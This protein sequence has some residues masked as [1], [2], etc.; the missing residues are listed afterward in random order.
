MSWC[1]GLCAELA[2]RPGKGRET[3]S[4]LIWTA[5]SS[6]LKTLNIC[7]FSNEPEFGSSTNSQRQIDKFLVALLIAHSSGHVS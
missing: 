2:V 6:R 1:E 3:G 7:D 4:P 5:G